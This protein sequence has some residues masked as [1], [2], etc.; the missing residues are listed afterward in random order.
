MTVEIWCGSWFVIIFAVSISSKCIQI[1]HAMKRK[2]GINQR[3][4]PFNDCSRKQGLILYSKRCELLRLLHTSYMYL[5]IKIKKQ[6]ALSTT[7]FIIIIN[8]FFNEDSAL[9]SGL[10]GQYTTVQLETNIWNG[11][12]Q[13]TR[14]MQLQAKRVSKISLCYI[15]DIL[16]TYIY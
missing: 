11:Y 14:N 6:K 3:T 7:C 16:V 9:F 15:R 13:N 4:Q 1:C 5:Q 12:L 8:R 2:R 10:L